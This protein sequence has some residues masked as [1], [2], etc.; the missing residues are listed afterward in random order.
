MAELAVL[1]PV[2]ELVVMGNVALVGQFLEV[3]CVIVAV[4]W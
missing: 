4:V 1:E 3:M 2:L